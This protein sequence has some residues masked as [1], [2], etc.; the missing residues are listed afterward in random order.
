MR[1]HSPGFLAVAGDASAKIEAAPQPGK[2]CIYI[3]RYNNTFAKLPVPYIRVPVHTMS[4]NI[5]FPFF[6]FPQHNAGYL[7]LCSPWGKIL[8]P[9]SPPPPFH[10]RRKKWWKRYQWNPFLASHTDNTNWYSSEQNSSNTVN[11]QGQ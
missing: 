5:F 7:S 6:Q 3:H 9:A 2:K 10:F 8:N 4:G 1:I 11:L